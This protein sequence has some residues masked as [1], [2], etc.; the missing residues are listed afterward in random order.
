MADDGPESL[1]LRLLRRIDEKVDRLAEDVR[2]A[3]QRLGALEEGQA[4]ISRRL[5][6]LD[7]RLERVERRL[8]LVE[9]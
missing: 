6:R 1:T 4:S 8:D 5:D 7:A 2:E 3:K 9:H